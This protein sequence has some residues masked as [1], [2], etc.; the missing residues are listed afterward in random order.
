MILWGL[1]VV[2]LAGFGW[3]VGM[4]R[5]GG[6]AGR[7]GGR[8]GECVVGMVMAMSR[9]RLKVGVGGCYYL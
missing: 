6:V 2:V 9:M 3:V 5:G 8:L 1:G 4:K 7:I